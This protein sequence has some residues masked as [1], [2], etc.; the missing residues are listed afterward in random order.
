MESNDLI[1]L[2]IAYY[3]D[4]T[5]KELLE[6]FREASCRLMEADADSRR[7][8][9]HE[10]IMSMAKFKMELEQ[11]KLEYGRITSTCGSIEAIDS[12]IREVECRIKQLSYK[13]NNMNY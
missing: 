5:Q 1:T 10:D 13:K 3:K 2:A 11:F 8:K 7:S 4:K 9:A 12:Y 6:R